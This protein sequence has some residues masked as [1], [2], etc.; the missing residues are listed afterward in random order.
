M[1]ISRL[2]E[3]TVVAQLEHLADAD[4]REGN[5][6]RGQL[7]YEA[8]G[9]AEFL[10][11]PADIVVRLIF[12]KPGE[13]VADIEHHGVREHEDVV[14]RHAA[15]RPAPDAAAYFA[16]RDQLVEMA[17]EIG[18]R[19][20]REHAVRLT[21]V[22]VHAG[23]RLVE[24]LRLRVQAGVVAESIAG[25]GGIGL[26]VVFQNRL[27]RRVDAAGGNAVAGDRQAAEAPV[28]RGH[29]RQRVVKLVLRPNG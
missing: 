17:E 13:A 19:I 7:R 10:E 1:I 12:L 8:G 29:R 16:A 9:E 2:L 21:E 15:V 26:G 28:G 11:V 4:L 25:S 14:E 23:Q 27:C 20:A 18:L 3:A 5:R 6:R 24:V 22:V